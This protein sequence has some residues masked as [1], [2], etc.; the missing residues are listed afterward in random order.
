VAI[1]GGCNPSTLVANTGGSTPP[2]TTNMRTELTFTTDDGTRYIWEGGLGA[3]LKSRELRV[4]E[5]DVRYIG[6]HL[7][8]AYRVY[9]RRFVPEIC[10]ALCGGCKF[11]QM[12]QVRRDLMGA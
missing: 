9:S 5:G 2:S 1:P 10:W 12:D 11:E 8:Y 7:F 6:G 4:K 3:T